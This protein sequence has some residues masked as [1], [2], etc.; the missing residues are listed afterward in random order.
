MADK[1][2]SETEVIEA[3]VLTVLSCV[4]PEL[5]VD[6]AGLAELRAKGDLSPEAWRSASLAAIEPA[7]IAANGQDAAREEQRAIAA[8]TRRIRTV[9]S[10]R[11]PR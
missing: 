6:L 3:R 4:D 8:A 7:L 2:I 9:Y 5:W 10:K 11:R 1:D